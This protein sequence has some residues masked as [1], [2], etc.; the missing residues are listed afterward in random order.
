MRHKELF[1]LHQKKK[2]VEQIKTCLLRRGRITLFQSWSIWCSYV[3]VKTSNVNV[4]VLQ[5]LCNMW[6]E[7]GQWSV[8]MNVKTVSGELVAAG[9][10]TEGI[11]QAQSRVQAIWMLKGIVVSWRADLMMH[12]F[13]RWRHFT[14][15][16]QKQGNGGLLRTIFPSSAKVDTE[17]ASKLTHRIN[18]IQN[19]H[20]TLTMIVQWCVLEGRR[21]MLSKL[22][23]FSQWVHLSNSKNRLSR[24]AQYLHQQTQWRT[25]NT[26]PEDRE[27]MKTSIALQQKARAVLIVQV[28]VLPSLY[29]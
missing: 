15:H 27:K 9:W 7:V 14:P 3:L 20:S 28:V 26:I 16:T 19:Q 10:F 12:A 5:H 2:A 21:R 13:S 25:E 23:A 22:H 8:G 1:A 18:S 6:L 29:Y 4:D 11:R 24:Q 17:I